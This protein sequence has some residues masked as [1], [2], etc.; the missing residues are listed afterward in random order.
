MLATFITTLAYASTYP[1]IHKQ[2]MMVVSDKAVAI[3]NI[4][5]CLGVILTDRI[6][7][8]KGK[9]LY[10]HYALFCNLETISTMSTTVFYF[11]ARDMV[12]YYLIDIIAF[13]VMTRNVICGGRR[14]KAQRYNTE[15]SRIKFENNDSTASSVATLI[16]SGIA[17][18]LNLPFE[19]MLIIATVGNCID[20]FMYIKIF[21][22]TKKG[23]EE[24]SMNKNILKAFICAI[25]ATAVLSTGITVSAIEPDYVKYNNSNATDIPKD[26]LNNLNELNKKLFPVVEMKRAE[27]VKKKVHKDKVKLRR[28]KK[29]EKEKRKARRLARKKKLERK[30]RLE[31][32]KRNAHSHYKVIDNGCTFTLDAAYQDYAYQQCVKYGI[33]DY[34]KYVIAMMYHESQFK[35]GCVSSTSDYG[36]MQ[37]NSC[38]FSW[39]RSKLGLD[40]LLNPYQ[41]ITAGVY[42]IADK[43]R[44]HG[45]IETALVGYNMGDGAVYDKGIYSSS[46]SRCVVSDTYKLVEVK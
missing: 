45:S 9:K 41:N 10:M 15:D 8:I 38:N 37:I 40:N 2:M 17:M 27:I 32:K 42:I 13:A 26:K 34:Y 39:L 1:Y 29:L 11:I 44:K 31:E 4:I 19:C 18:I 36:L 23:E 12:S 22:I 24:S 28:L 14:L 33:R 35:T 30:R 43:I 6:W 7:Q 5:V 3:A 25:S 46:Y 16:G 20:N 21:Y